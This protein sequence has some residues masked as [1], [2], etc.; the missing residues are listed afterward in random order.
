[1]SKRYLTLLEL[2]I[3]LAIIA[4]LA[5][6]VLDNFAG[7]EMRERHRQTTARGEAIQRIITGTDTADGIGAFLT[8][9]GRLP[10]VHIDNSA[11]EP[12]GRLL[13]QL[14]DRTIFRHDESGTTMLNH[15]AELALTREL[16]DLPI[17]LAKYPVVRMNVGWG[18]PYLQ[19]TGR[20]LFDG[21]GNPWRIIADY[22]LKPE[23]DRLVPDYDEPTDT[24]T[25]NTQID[26]I[27]SFGADNAAD[28]GA[29]HEYADRDQEF[30]FAHE[31][32]LS[33]LIITLKMRDDD[34]PAVWREPE[35]FTG[36]IAAY[37]AAISYGEGDMVKLG[38]RVYRSLLG[39]N[40]NNQPDESPGHWLQIH[41]KLVD[42]AA[43]MLFAPVK[44][45]ARN[46]ASG[47]MDI[48]YYRFESDG[49]GAVPLLDRSGDPDQDQVSS[50]D[51]WKRRFI[52][53]QEWESAG[54]ARVERLTP[55][56]RRILGY[57]YRANGANYDLFF[58]SAQEWVT[59]L[60][61][62]NYIT[63]YLERQ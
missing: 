10:A 48:G 53:E 56:R 2:V 1:M 54:V 37:S 21:W 57:A 9:M 29:N 23:S 7:Q 44:R 11:E 12:A 38:S 42:R 58:I 18:G 26:G 17:A 13:A 43:V 22:R 40:L 41:S 61:G 28:S 59:L 6:V 60:P 39:G 15:A 8:D 35:T 5:A 19:N 27:A 51:V 63:L 62:N 4:V 50:A 14:Y 3:T 47:S 49:A 36:T 30:I 25:A 34:N 45:G 16:M 24:P 31:E 52:A 20:A 55:G 33:T 32:M 46:V